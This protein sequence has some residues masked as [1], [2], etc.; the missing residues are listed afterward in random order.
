MLRDAKADKQIKTLREVRLPMHRFFIVLMAGVFSFGIA[1]AETFFF[2]GVN[3]NLEGIGFQL[4]VDVTDGGSGLAQFVF[5]NDGPINSVTGGIFF[6]SDELGSFF[7]AVGTPPS[8]VSYVRAPVVTAAISLKVTRSVSTA[9][10]LSRSVAGAPTES[11][12]T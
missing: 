6:D 7:S 9:I 4:S 8:G 5:H 2:T 10:S 11:T 3:A 1:Q 12:T